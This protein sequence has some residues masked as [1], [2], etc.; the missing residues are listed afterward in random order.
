MLARRR[1][2]LDLR[3]AARASPSRASMPGSRF[4]KS[5]FIA[6]SVCGRWIVFL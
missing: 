3:V 4:G 1:V 2:F 6:K 5:A